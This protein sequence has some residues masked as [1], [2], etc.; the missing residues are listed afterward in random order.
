MSWQFF[1]PTKNPRVAL[2]EL[3]RS[4]PQSG[5]YTG[6]QAHIRHL[7]SCLLVFIAGCSSAISYALCTALLFITELLTAFGMVFLREADLIHMSKF[8]SK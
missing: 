8:L 3:P 4:F 6:N 5:C 2:S 1:D 7:D